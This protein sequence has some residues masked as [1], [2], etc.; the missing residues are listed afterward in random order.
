[1]PG[2]QMPPRRMRVIIYAR[3][4]QDAHQGRSVEQQLRIGRKRAEANGWEVVGV[5]W[6]NDVSASEYARGVRE[7]WPKVEELIRSGAADILWLWELSRGTRE[8][9]V[10][11]HL[12]D[13]CQKHSMYIGL[14]KRLWDTTDPD[15][16]GYLDTQM[17]KVIQESGQTRKRVLRDIN[18]N[19]EQGG[20]HGPVPY[21]YTRERDP[22]TGELL[23]QVPHPERSK[24]ILEIAEMLVEKK[25]TPTAIAAEFNR[26][27]LRTPRGYLLGEWRE[28]KSGRMIQTEGWSWNVVVGL[29]ES[30]SVRG[31]RRHKG[32][33]IEQGGWEPVFTPQRAREVDQ[34]I[35]SRRREDGTA[36][37]EKS[38]KA[39]LSG[40]AICDICEGPI[41]LGPSQKKGKEPVK[42]YRCHGT[43]PGAKVHGARTLPRLEEAVEQLLF[44]RLDHPDVRA[45]L[46]PSEESGPG[47]ERETA[48]EVQAEIEDLWAAVEVGRIS[49]QRAEQAEKPMLTRL[50]VARQAA[51]PPMVDPLV[52]EIAGSSSPRTVWAG[53]SVNQRRAALR[54]LTT[55]IR[56]LRL[57]KIGRRVPAAYEHVRIVWAGVGVSPAE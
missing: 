34:A 11:A 50:E 32:R 12:V 35:A 18:A 33:D 51:I 17:A 5:F 49:W 1:M 14:D 13:A 4:S 40:I 25:M 45:A 24:L 28:T 54:L 7:Y 29:V 47:E 41:Y 16:M 56:M 42:V 10:W 15:D 48:E 26:R 36:V 22:D 57:G 9:I 30:P 55:E 3:V 38:A 2:E 20:P 44:E 27:G 39:L 23:R 53:W 37:R 8:R 19:A 46:R 21:A 6:D 52:M 43:G 31:R